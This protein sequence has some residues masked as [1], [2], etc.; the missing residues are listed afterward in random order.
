MTRLPV[1][2][3]ADAA[4][5][6][7]QPPPTARR[8]PLVALAP[9]DPFAPGTFSGLSHR[10][11]DELVR[12]GWD[13]TSFA[14]RDLRWHDLARGA[15]RPR[16]ALR[17]AT[18]DRRTPV[19]DPDWAWSQRGFERLSARLAR[20]L[21]AIPVEVP[22]LQVGTQVDASG[23]RPGRPVHCI[24]D[25][26][27]VQALAADEFAVSRASSAVQHEAVACQRRVFAGCRRVLTLS[28]WTRR[29]VIDDYGIAPERVEVV[30]A[31]ANLP[32]PLPRRTD[33]ARPTV[34]FVGRD[35]HQKGGPLLLDAF[36]LVRRLRPAARLVVVGCHPPLEDEPGVEVVGVLD[37]SRPTGDT[38]LRALYASATCLALL[39]RFDAFPNVLLEAGAAGVPVVSTHE[40]SRAEAVVDGTT[41]LLVA[42]R[43]PEAV[44]DALLEVIDHPERADAMGRTAARR[45]AARFTWPVVAARVAQ[46]V[47]GS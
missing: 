42:T 44:A 11:F 37:R 26:T 16:A 34:L 43:T 36:R 21:A 47:G 35:W 27:V 41:G 13:V 3:V 1:P 4:G 12:Q 8:T 6:V 45:V 22:V 33:P 2:D 15:V 5:R 17:R 30:G 29:S 25:C 23:G 9:A 28:E 38:R 19:V 40:G 31:G 10:L 32:A 14:T 20:R 46:V 7:R 18:A 24:T 39:S